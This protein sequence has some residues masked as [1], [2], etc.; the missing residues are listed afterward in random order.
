[1][2]TEPDEDVAYAKVLVRAAADDLER[3]MEHW[4]RLKP[5]YGDEQTEATSALT[6][7]G[8]CVGEAL[9]RLRAAI[10]EDP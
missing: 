6:E 9:A 8:L 10:G 3:A 1:M 7:I 5:L 2:I 4:P